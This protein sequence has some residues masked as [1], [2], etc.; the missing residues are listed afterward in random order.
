VNKHGKGRS[1]EQTLVVTS[2]ILSNNKLTSVE[3]LDTAIEAVADS[4]GAVE[5]LD[6]SFNCL[7][8]IDE[9]PLFESL[10]MLSQHLSGPVEIP[11]PPNALLARKQDR[12]APRH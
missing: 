5:W 10:H 4:P 2:V 6:L 12:K 3:Q 1:K 11:Q 9:V 7:T 8:T